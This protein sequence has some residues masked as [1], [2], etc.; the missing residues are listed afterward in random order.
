M[1][2]SAGTG[3]VHGVADTVGL[4][5]FSQD[6]VGSVLYAFGA[7]P[8]DPRAHGI[9]PTK[10]QI[11]GGIEGVTGPLYEPKTQAGKMAK[12]IGETVPYLGFG[13]GVRGSLERALKE[14]QALQAR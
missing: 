10:S 5:G 11:L 12:T 13:A 9:N 2:K 1:A 4:A 8:R 6:A 3:L 7:P 14:L